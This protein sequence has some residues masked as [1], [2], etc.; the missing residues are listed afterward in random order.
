MTEASCKKGRKAET[1]K[2]K[3]KG[4]RNKRKQNRENIREYFKMGLYNLYPMIKGVT[5]M[6]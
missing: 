2:E 4:K 3:R 1:K 5:S 6:K